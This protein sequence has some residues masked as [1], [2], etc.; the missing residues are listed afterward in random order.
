MTD[1]MTDLTAAWR[2]AKQ[3]EADANVR[4]IAIESRIYEL[5][6]PHLPDKGTYT[7][8]SGMKITTGFSEEWDQER[9]DSAYKSW[10]DG[11]KFPFAGSWKPDGKAISYLRGNQPSLYAML[12]PA[13]TLKPKKPSFSLPTDK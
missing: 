9:V 2:E 5:T 1:Q 13:L 12:S 3:A 7:T 8:D 11:V 6:A 4:R 10:P